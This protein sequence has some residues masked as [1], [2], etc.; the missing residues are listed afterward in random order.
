MIAR[1]LVGLTL[2]AALGL[3]ATVPSS[4]R[5]QSSA[6]PNPTLLVTLVIDQLRFD[7]L[8]RYQRHWSGGL[9]RLLTEGA[10]FERAMYPYL[11][12][13]T[14]AGHATIATGA[15][16]YRHGIILNEWYRRDVGRRMACT[17]DDTVTSV[18]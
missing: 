12:T 7:Y 11:N 4:A 2:A 15:L 8:E 13:V 14:C 5:I 10:V 9:R 18:P 3:A 6:A 16:P 1:L 17:D